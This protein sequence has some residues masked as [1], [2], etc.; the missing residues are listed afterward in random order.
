MIFI[1]PEVV[2]HET[3]AILRKKSPTE[4]L[5]IAHGMWRS[6]RNMLLCALRSQHPEWTDEQ[7]EREVSRRLSHG[8]V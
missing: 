3:A 5:A 7:V 6:A 8:A 1:P 2:D 4:R